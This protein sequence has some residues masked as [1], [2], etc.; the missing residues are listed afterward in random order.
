MNLNSLTH[1]FL[2]G[3][4][5]LTN[6]AF[7]NFSRL[8]AL[9]VLDMWKCTRVTD[10]G[11]KKYYDVEK[12]LGLSYLSKLCNLR[13]LNLSACPI[14]NDGIDHLTELSSLEKLNTYGCEEVDSSGIGKLLRLP[15]FSV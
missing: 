15:K 14:T 3:C 7:V 13:R 4:E 5:T 1:L 6:E 8:Q 2:L 11:K 12:N 10:K 9:E